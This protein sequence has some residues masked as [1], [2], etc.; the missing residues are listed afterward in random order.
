MAKYAAREQMK[1]RKKFFFPVL[2]VQE[3]YDSTHLLKRTEPS[4]LCFPP[5]PK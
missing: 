5:L 2:G 3:L 4:F 1:K